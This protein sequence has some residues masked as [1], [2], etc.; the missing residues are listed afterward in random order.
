MAWI[1]FQIINVSQYVELHSIEIILI[2]VDFGCAECKFVNQLKRLPFVR[3]IV[4]VDIDAAL[5]EECDRRT[6]PLY[7]DY[8]DPRPFTPIDLVKT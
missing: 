3:E 6:E 7:I 1:F 8:L 4:G 5:L 2:Q